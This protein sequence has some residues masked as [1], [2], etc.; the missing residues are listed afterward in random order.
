MKIAVYHT[1]ILPTLHLHKIC[2]ILWKDKVPNM[3]V[4]VHCGIEGIEALL[5][6]SLHHGGAC[7][8]GGQSNTKANLLGGAQK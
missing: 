1:V 2:S 8:N 5:I 7:P 4:L 3:A 6:K